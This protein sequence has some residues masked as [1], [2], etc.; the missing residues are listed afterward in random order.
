MPSFDP[1]GLKINYTNATIRKRRSD[2]L[3]CR[4][5]R[6]AG[7]HLLSNCPSFTRQNKFPL[8]QFPAL[9]SS[10]VV[11][12][13][14]LR[15]QHRSSSAASQMLHFKENGANDGSQGS[16][17][18]AICPCSFLPAQRPRFPMSTWPADKTRKRK[19]FFWFSHWRPVS[20][21]SQGRI[22]I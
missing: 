7:S 22:P 6:S 16:F 19:V 15:I 21:S 8:S 17:Q 10:H 20:P 11:L 1:S 2:M 13:A 12:N 4:V 3:N 9:Q 18:P 14:R 5:I